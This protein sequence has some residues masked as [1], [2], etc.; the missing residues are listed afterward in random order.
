MT[1]FSPLLANPLLLP[2]LCLSYKLI[3]IF[4]I[5]CIHDCVCVWLFM[6]ECIC[7][8]VC[9]HDCGGDACMSV[10]GTVCMY[11]C[12]SIHDSVW[13]YACMSVHVGGYTYMTV[14]GYACMSVYAG[15]Y[16][17][18]T[19][20]GYACMSVH[21]GGYAYMTVCGVCMHE[22]VCRRVC[23]H[24]CG[25]MH[26]WVCMR[27]CIAYMTVGGYACTTVCGEYACM[28]SESPLNSQELSYRQLLA[29]WV[30]WT[31][32]KSSAWAACVLNCWATFPVTSGLQFPLYLFYIVIV[33]YT[34]HFSFLNIFPVDINSTQTVKWE[35]F[36]DAARVQQ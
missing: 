24:D 29:M 22:C 30:L 31:E 23:I 14:G 34:I 9:I 12:I 7:G 15:G 19:M 18:M 8:R 3:F 16:A 32:D 26:A 17:Y 13:G 11:E 25:G 5:L 27:V 33:Y 21:A 6:H 28:S 35:L 4:E 2:S 1:Y 20:G 36:R 10:C